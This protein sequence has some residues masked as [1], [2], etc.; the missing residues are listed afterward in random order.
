MDCR[1]VFLQTV[2]SQNLLLAC[3]RNHV[4]DSLQSPRIYRVYYRCADHDQQRHEESRLAIEGDQITLFSPPESNRTSSQRQQEIQGGQSAGH[5]TAHQRRHQL[6]ARDLF[7]PVI[8][9]QDLLTGD[10]WD[11]T[12]EY[13]KE[14]AVE[15]GH[16]R[17]IQLI[18]LLVKISFCIFGSKDHLWLHPYSQN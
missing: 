11:K 17:I 5:S 16:I 13:W 7:F 1:Y 10:H 8:Q 12:N 4:W 15:I 6:Q 3:S 9:N 18:L 2:S 14:L